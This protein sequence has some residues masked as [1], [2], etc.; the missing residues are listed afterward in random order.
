MALVCTSLL[1][2][3]DLD[4]LPPLHSLEETKVKV[5]RAL[6]DDFDTPKAINAMEEMI[7]RANVEL[8]NKAQTAVS[9]WP[10]SLIV[11]ALVT[12][13]TTSDTTVLVVNSGRRAGQK[14]GCHCSNRCLRR[15]IHG[16]AGSTS[17]QEGR[18]NDLLK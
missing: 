11:R 16:P 8:G 17:F 7:Y 10:V 15:Q 14:S 18:H 1:P 13:S 5:E 2:V 12:C 9:V 6:A 3:Y 4:L